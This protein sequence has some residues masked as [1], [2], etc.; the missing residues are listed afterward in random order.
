MKWNAILYGRFVYL[1]IQKCRSAEKQLASGAPARFIFLGADLLPCVS[2]ISARKHI[3]SAVFADKMFN[4][5]GYRILSIKGI[6]F[7]ETKF[8]SR[9][10]KLALSDS[11]L[12]QKYHLKSE[13]SP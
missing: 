9:K 7:R 6:K 12:S 13:L 2:G 8:S 10:Q 5:S 3:S 1:D 11:F 4:I